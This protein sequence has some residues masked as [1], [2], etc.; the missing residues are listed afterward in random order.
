MYLV[1]M[2]HIPNETKQKPD[3]PNYYLVVLF[4]FTR[5]F[6]CLSSSQLFLNIS[7]FT[8]TISP[9]ASQQSVIKTT[10]LTQ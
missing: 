7:I 4:I 2:F 5:F 8:H 10:L 6:S 9:N 3:S 1:L